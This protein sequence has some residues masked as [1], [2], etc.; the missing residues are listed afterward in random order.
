MCHVRTMERCPTCDAL[1]YIVLH[2]FGDDEQTQIASCCYLDHDGVLCIT[3]VFYE[4]DQ[5]PT[6]KCLMCG[7]GV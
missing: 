3:P 5:E 6:Y 7:F 1:L 4:S 2:T